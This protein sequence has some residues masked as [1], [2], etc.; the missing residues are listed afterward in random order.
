MS[1]GS[2][3]Q[4]YRHRRPKRKPLLKFSEDEQGA[5]DNKAAIRLG[6][7][8]RSGDLDE[9]KAFFGEKGIAETLGIMFSFEIMV[10]RLAVFKED[11]SLPPAMEAVGIKVTPLQLA[12]LCKQSQL[13]ELLLSSAS[14]TGMQEL[15]NM[16]STRARIHFPEGINNYADKDKT[17]QAHLLFEN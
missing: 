4:K 13:L 11:E 5:E 17:L 15:N 3:R 1:D 12:V 2:L 6:E 10:Q 7:A 9:V 16:L 8:I 14:S